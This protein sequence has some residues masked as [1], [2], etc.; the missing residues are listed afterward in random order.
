MDA[1]AA[2]EELT[3]KMQRVLI[4][5]SSSPV[6]STVSV[7]ETDRAS[8]DRHDAVRDAQQRTGSVVKTTKKKR[9]NRE[10]RGEEITISELRGVS[11]ETRDT[12]ERD[13]DDDQHCE[14]RASENESSSQETDDAAA[15]DG[16]GATAADAQTTHALDA[17]SLCQRIGNVSISSD[18]S[19]RR[20]S[21]DRSDGPLSATGDAETTSSQRPSAAADDSSAVPTGLQS[22][23]SRSPTSSSSSPALVSRKRRGVFGPFGI[24]VKDAVHLHH[25]HHHHHRSSTTKGK[26][27]DK[28]HHL[29]GPSTAPLFPSAKKQKLMAEVGDSFLTVVSRKVSSSVKA[30]KTVGPSESPASPPPSPSPL[31]LPLKSSSSAGGNA[32]K[33]QREAL[34]DHDASG[35]TSDDDRSAYVLHATKRHKSVAPSAVGASSPDRVTASSSH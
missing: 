16:E 24:D 11:V 13:G 3:R 33:R 1:F 32:H 20:G 26:S 27:K 5:P 25:H 7:T 19:T 8:D 17:S 15:V 34:L 12:V 18:P 22:P 6:A 4:A 21:S 28:H 35:D 2:I 23:Q 31:P 9:T 10:M 29:A 30:T 14:A